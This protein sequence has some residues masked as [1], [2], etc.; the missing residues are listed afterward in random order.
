MMTQSISFEI[1][2]QDEFNNTKK[3]VNNKQ[4]GSHEWGVFFSLSPHKSLGGERKNKE[5]KNNLWG[6][7]K[8]W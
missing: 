1:S 8:L 5:R 7:P 6:T 4:N 3:Y 2:W